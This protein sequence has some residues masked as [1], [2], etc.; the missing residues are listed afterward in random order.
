MFALTLDL[1]SPCMNNVFR[2]I[3]LGHIVY[4]KDY[5]LVFWVAMLH[6]LDTQIGKVRGEARTEADDI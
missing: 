3:L 1:R 2:N 4:Y 5:Y 6:S